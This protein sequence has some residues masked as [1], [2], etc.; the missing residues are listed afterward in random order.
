M[1]HTL[2]IDCFI[3]CQGLQRNARGQSFVHIAAARLNL[4]VP[5]IVLAYSS[6]RPRAVSKVLR[7]AAAQGLTELFA[8]VD[9]EGVS[10]RMLLEQHLSARQA[11]VKA[12]L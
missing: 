11:T 4:W 1:P 8:A 10:P 2:N 6:V 7:F 3:M 9:G 5:A 12:V